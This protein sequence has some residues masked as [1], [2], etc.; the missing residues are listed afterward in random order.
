MM[1]S[2]EV[3]I[4]ILGDASLA[5]RLEKIAYNALPATIS[6]DWWS[7]QYV[8]QSNQVQCVVAEDRVYVNN[9]P[10]AN[11]FGLEPN[12]G[13]CT[14]NMHQGWPK[15][16]QHM[17]MAAP[18]GLAMVAIGPCAVEAK[19]GGGGVK[20]LVEGGYPFAEGVGIKVEADGEEP[21]AIHVRIPGWASRASVLTHR[22]E[23]HG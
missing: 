14:A 22:A 3:A 6:D 17:W 16:V 12:F 1:Y 13:C 11:I 9:G 7:H 4:A 23:W 10:D 21:F 19:A 20:I 2:L 8:Q 18:D 15:F 5:D